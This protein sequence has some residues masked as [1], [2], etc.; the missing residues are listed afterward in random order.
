MT[1]KNA[2]QELRRAL[3]EFHVAA[4]EAEL[5]ADTHGLL[6]KKN[7]VTLANHLR[8]NDTANL[9][10]GLLRVAWVA[11]EREPTDSNIRALQACERELN[12][13]IER[14]EP[15]FPAPPVYH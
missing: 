11:V 13:L 6:I 15:S 2:I 9:V 7:R 12:R 10:K 14:F 8:F 5:D 4:S 1:A 3:G